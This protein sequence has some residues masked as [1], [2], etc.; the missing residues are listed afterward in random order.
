MLLSP[1]LVTFMKIANFPILPTCNAAIKNGRRNLPTEFR[2]KTENYSVSQIIYPP[3]VFW[4]N[5]P[6]D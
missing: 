6:N 1:Y 4:T 2:V 5:I 3:D